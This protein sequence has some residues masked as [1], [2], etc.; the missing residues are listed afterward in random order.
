MAELSIIQGGKFSAPPF[1]PAASFDGGGPP[2]D[3]SGM[4]ARVAKLEVFAEDAKQRLVRIEAK[5][6][7]MATKDELAKMESSLIKWIVGTAI[8][9][10][11]IAVTV[12]GFVMPQQQAPAPIVHTP[13]P[14]PAAPTVIVVP[15]P[16]AQPASS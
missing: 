1:K 6:D 2:S 3:N 10:G 13:Q 16:A 8:A 7:H 14:A 4:E 12:I 9:L 5:L 11:T 15:T